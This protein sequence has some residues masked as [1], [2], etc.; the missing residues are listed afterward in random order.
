MAGGSDAADRTEPATQRR[1][2]R[3]RDEGQVA[4][5]TELGQLVLLA[6][7]AA[8]M[9]MRAPAEL[10]RLRQSLTALLW[11]AGATDGP[12]GVAA[13]GY[14]A[15][16]AGGR[17]LIGVC[18]IAVVGAAAATLLQTGFLFNVRALQPDLAR[19]SPRRG[20]RRVFGVHNLTTAGKS[21][22]KAGLIGWALWRLLSQRR[23]ALTASMLQ[24]SAGLPSQLLSLA[25]AV[26]LAALTVQA[27]VALGDQVLVRLRHAKSLRMSRSEVRDEARESDG[28]PEMKAR[29]RRLRMQ[30]ARR[31]MVAAVQEATVVVTNPTHYAVALAYD[32]TRHAAPRVVAKG[33]DEMAARIRAIAEEHRVPIVANPPLARALHR[34]ELETDVPAEHFA[35]VAELIAYVWRLQGQ[36]RRTSALPPPP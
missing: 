18:A 36:V 13:A 33:M 17:A 9:L 27:G 4:V 35:A 34:V 22:L 8:F 30:R 7:I 15:A 29:I 3:A 21:L 25:V 23:G 11:A 5:S 14:Q 16:L 20:L 10:G 28:N 6:G 19:L 1:V 24:S 32:R 31:R 2:Q 12:A 26:V